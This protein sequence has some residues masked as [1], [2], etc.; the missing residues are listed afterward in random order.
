MDFS[1]AFV[2]V[3]QDILVARRAMQ[4]AARRGGGGGGLDLAAWVS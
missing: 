4:T 2:R 3:H 1:T